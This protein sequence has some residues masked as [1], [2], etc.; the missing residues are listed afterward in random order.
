MKT[1]A[2]TLFASVL[3]AII[4]SASIFTA[5]AADGDLN[6]LRSSVIDFNK[7]VITGNVKVELVQSS[8]QRVEVYENYNKETT[9]IIQ[10]GDKL[11][12]NSAEEEPINIVVYVKDLQRIDASNTVSVITR[13]KFS[14]KVLQVFLKDGASAYVNA[15]IG[16]LY[17]VI[18]DHAGL[19]LKGS[20]NDHTLVKSQIAKLKMDNFAALKTTTSS[21]DEHDRGTSYD[22]AIVKDTIKTT[23]I[24]R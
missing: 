10:K 3:T 11:I 15:E 2:K 23:R 5:T 8:K 22:T 13:G 17:T 18:K 1:L 19:K 9:S 4:L 21:M 24:I 20:S 6:I 14:S 12:I 16:S 7:V